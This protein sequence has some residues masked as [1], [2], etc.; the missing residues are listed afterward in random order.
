[1]KKIFFCALALLGAT[2]SISAQNINWR[3]FTPQQNHLIQLQ[4]GWDYGITLGFGYGYRFHTRIPILA[5][6]EFSAP[7]GEHMFDDF[8]TMIGAQA[9]VLNLGGFSATI[10]AYSPIRRFENTRVKMF[11]F[12]SEFS[13]V[14]GFYKPGWFA[15]GEFG[16]DKAI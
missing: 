2:Y 16:F 8:K 12:G 6:L 7:A 1:M 10:K 4:T 9:R 15:A 14:L 13:G 3:A 11:S 5:N